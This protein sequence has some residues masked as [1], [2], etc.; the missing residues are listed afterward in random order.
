MVVGADPSQ[1]ADIFGFEVGGVA[2]GEPGAAATQKADSFGFEGKAL[3]RAGRLGSGMERCP[4][5][6]RRKLLRIAVSL[7]PT[8]RAIA[9]LECPS[10]FKW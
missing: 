7:T 10:A 1:K 3:S 8:R 5:P 4:H 2:K 6:I 9:Q